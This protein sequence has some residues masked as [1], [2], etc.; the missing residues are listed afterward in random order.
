MRD[1][2]KIDC[3]C[4]EVV[5]CLCSEEIGGVESFIREEGKGDFWGK[6]K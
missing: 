6:R 2:Q 4:F 5:A 3:V 1:F